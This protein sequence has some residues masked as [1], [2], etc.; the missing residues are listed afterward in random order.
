MTE[1]T[2]WDTCTAI[3]DGNISLG[4]LILLLFPASCQLMASETAMMAPH[5]ILGRPGFKSPVPALCDLVLA[6]AGIWGVN[7]WLVGYIAMF[8]SAF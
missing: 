7:H 5:H 4:D 6:V 8:L 2:A 3:P 1:D